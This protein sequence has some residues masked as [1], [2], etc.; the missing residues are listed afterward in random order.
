MSSIRRWVG[1]GLACVL[2]AC[3]FGCV[4]TTG[5]RIV[6]FE[7]V[8]GG[9]EDAANPLAFETERGYAVTLTRARL[10]VGAVYLN[11]TAPI[12][13]AQESSCL[14]PGLYAG[15]VT[16]S[17]DVDLLSSEL[18]RFPERGTGNSHPAV[19]GE[20]WLTGGEVNAPDDNTPILRVAGTAERGEDRFPFEGTLTIGSNRTGPLKNSALP[21]ADPICRQRIV[22]PI[23]L[24]LMLGQGGTLVLRIDPR[25]LFANVEFSELENEGTEDAPSYR[26]DDAMSNQP[27][28]AL[29]NGLRSRS[30]VYALA[31][32]E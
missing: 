3:A 17:L 30:G 12:S 1:G 29:F 25:G 13:V 15:Q 27:S 18:V 7:A 21:G 11:E 6:S 14:L 10:H 8:A 22:S 19:V 5:G 4:E 26:F 28:I 16:S 31:F 24:E 20:V 9:P 23:P 2:S 32:V